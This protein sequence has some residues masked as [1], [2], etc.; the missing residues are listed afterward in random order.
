MFGII[1]EGKNA[2][3]ISEDSNLSACTVLMYLRGRSSIKA[4]FYFWVF[5]LLY[6]YYVSLIYLYF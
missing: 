1:L 2:D 4:V 5:S 6:M 3:L